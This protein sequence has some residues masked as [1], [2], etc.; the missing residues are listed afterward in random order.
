MCEMIA[1]MRFGV[2]RLCMCRESGSPWLG[3]PTMF[4]IERSEGFVW[5]P[6]AELEFL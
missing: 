3:L 4:G 5:F 2:R 6:V 1:C